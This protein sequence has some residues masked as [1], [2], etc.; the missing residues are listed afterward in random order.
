MTFIQIKKP[1]IVWRNRLSGMATCRQRLCSVYLTQATEKCSAEVFFT[2]G[3][4]RNPAQIEVACKGLIK[5]KTLDQE[6]ALYQQYKTN[7]SLLSAHNLP[8]WCDKNLYVPFSLKPHLSLTD[9]NSSLTRWQIDMVTWNLT[10]DHCGTWALWPPASSW[11]MNQRKARCTTW[12]KWPIS[13]SWYVILSI[14][15]HY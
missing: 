3:E 9:E 4:E 11:W 12:L 10:W 8:G 6:E 14:S 7:Q 2:K 13:H 5:N 15:L 1:K